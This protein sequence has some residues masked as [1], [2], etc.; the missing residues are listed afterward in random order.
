M[1]IPKFYHNLTPL[2]H[3]NGCSGIKVWLN[4]KPS[5]SIVKWECPAK[6]RS[7]MKKSVVYLLYSALLLM[8]LGLF[9]AASAQTENIVKFQIQLRDNV[10]VQMGAIVITSQKN[11]KK[12]VTLLVINGTGQTANTFRPLAQALVKS[13]KTGNKVARVILLDYPGHGN[14][15][16]PMPS[17][18]LK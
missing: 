17:S 10:T 9:D 5:N 4:Y 8:V 12:G 13:E 14:S 15:A 2:F 1:S 18:A 6:E 3:R 11:V 7:R 16:L